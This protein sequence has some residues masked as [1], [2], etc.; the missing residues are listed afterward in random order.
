MSNIYDKAFFCE[1]SLK[2]KIISCFSKKLH[3][4]FL[5]GFQIHLS[6]NMFS[7]HYK[8]NKVN[9]I[10]AA[11]IFSKIFK[12]SF[13][14]QRISGLLQFFQRQTNFYTVTY[15]NQFRMNNFGA[16]IA[17]IHCSQKSGLHINF[18]FLKS[19]SISHMSFF[20]IESFSLYQENNVFQCIH[21]KFVDIKIA[22]LSIG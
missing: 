2:L 22:P 6:S 12:F 14:V 3:H 15:Q 16:Q 10:I 19:S 4:I 20:S 21:K 8:Y 17:R 7:M 5:R 1:N 9:K 18:G 11:T 13:Y